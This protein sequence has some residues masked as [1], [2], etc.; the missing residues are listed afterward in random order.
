MD[1]GLERRGLL[2]ACAEAATL[3]RAREEA[4]LLAALGGSS[5]ELSPAELRARVPA[6]APDVAG[7]IYFP[8]DAH[9]EPAAFVRGLAEQA[10]ARGVRMFPHTEVIGLERQGAR[11]TRVVA[12][13]G[14]FVADEVVL[15][16]GAWL[17]ELARLLGVRVP[18]QAAKGYSLTYRK[19]KGFGDT[20][21]MLSEAR[22]GVSPTRETLRF[23]GTLELAGLDLRIQTRRVEA[24]RRAAQRFLPG[25][26]PLERVET[27]RGLRPCTPDDL[28][29]L[30]RSRAA[31]NLSLVGGHG[32]S[33]LAQGP[34]SGALLAQLLTGEPTELDLAP[35]SPDRF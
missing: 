6:L 7:G 31:S 26:P 11:I 16:A 13:R 12:N 4:R 15:A 3:E 27:W 17:P 14:E 24:I 10:R 18:I 1:C 2:L 20:P 23:A 33:G 9:V 29:L 25:L 34:I 32:M 5:E 28:P 22:V 21:V 30:G 8:V 35:F 19:P